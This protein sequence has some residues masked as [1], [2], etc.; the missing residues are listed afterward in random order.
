MKVAR[1]ARLLP[2]R[3]PELPTSLRPTANRHSVSDAAH[4][5]GKVVTSAGDVQ[6]WRLVV[7]A[8]CGLADMCAMRL[9]LSGANLKHWHCL[10]DPGGVCAVL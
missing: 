8:L 6:G 9:R 7:A 2:E 1:P 4:R 10:A 5:L 3:L